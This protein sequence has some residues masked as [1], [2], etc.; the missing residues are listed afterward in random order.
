MSP[1]VAARSI[2]ER[3][4]FRAQATIIGALPE[5]NGPQDILGLEA[6]LGQR[7]NE[8]DRCAVVPGLE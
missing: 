3:F 7:L 5:S 6:L 8:T 1:K 2:L 4:R